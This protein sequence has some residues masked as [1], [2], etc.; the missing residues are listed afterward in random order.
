[1][2]PVRPLLLAVGVFAWDQPLADPVRHMAPHFLPA[3]DVVFMA[4]VRRS[5]LAT[6]LRVD[7]AGRLDP[8]FWQLSQIAGAPAASA[9][10]GW[11]VHRL[12]GDRPLV[13]YVNSY[14]AELG[15]ELL[16]TL[17]PDR[18]IYDVYEH[19]VAPDSPLPAAH[20]QLWDAAS[21][22][23]ALN[24]PVAAAM[25][26]P[27]AH[28]ILGAAVD[29][30]H[31]AAARAAQGPFAHAFAF[32]GNFANWVDFES[33]EAVARRFPTERLLLVGP[34]P[35]ALAS[36]LG[37]LRTFPNVTWQTQVPYADLPAILGSA[38]VL[39]LPRTT[40]PAAAAS[41]P[42]KLYDYLATGRPV[43]ATP[44]PGVAGLPAGVVYWGES[45]SG[46]ADACGQALA[47]RRT[48]ASAE[49]AQLR[50]AVAERRS[51]AQ[52]AAAIWQAAARW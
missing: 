6:R 43:A 23:V 7:L 13:L 28:L 19:V 1:M 36:D 47:E 9:I 11:Q 31:F 22:R 51:W 4:P 30:S 21:V 40:H 42:L 20:R 41:D 38:E 29:A 49:R 12:L 45:G 8:A 52:R 33:L 3:A 18:L 15:G 24:A 5:T 48:G 16:A 10:A 44:L 39:L 50:I 37:R 34:C 26:P 27:A 46:F 2:T 14:A 32:V 17:A 25:A 35:P